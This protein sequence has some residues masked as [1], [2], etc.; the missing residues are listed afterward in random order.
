MLSVQEALTAVFAQVPTLE[1]EQAPLLETR[2]RV[3]AY[4]ALADIDNPP[5]DNSAVDGFG[6]R[7]DD[8]RGAS[9]SVP[10]QLTCVGEVPA[11]SAPV[12]GLGPGECMRVMTGAPIPPGAD[13]MVMVEDTEI[14]GNRVQISLEAGEGDHIRRAA[15]D[16]RKGQ[17]VLPRGT[18]IGPAEIALLA[19]IGQPNVSVIRTPRVAVISTG[20]EIVDIHEKPGPGKIRN[21]NS[22][23]LA[24]LVAEAGGELHSMRHIPDDRAA[25]EAAFRECSGLDGSPRADAI[26]SSGGV[27][28]GDRDFVRPVIETLGTLELWR[29]KMKPGKPL[30]FGKVGRSLFFGLPGNP[31][32]TMVTFELF[33]RPSIWKMA[34]RTTLARPSV[35]AILESPVQ[36]TSGRQEY[37][38][39]VL[40][41]RDGQYYASPTGAQGSSFLTS[42]LG[43]NGLLVIDESSGD[44]QA[45]E[46]VLAMML[47]P[48][49]CTS[50][51][52]GS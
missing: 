32:S 18:L 28:V 17:R 29:V 12:R 6:V 42:M 52:A 5:F 10:I 38:R 23:A 43:A 3:L 16:I 34:G 51:S 27:S 20:D 39:A 19:T 14:T 47:M 1:I 44:L 26:V 45:G 2:N 9:K 8:T 49:G 24:A 40:T 33:V 22:Y 25:T 50:G 13:A 4:D 15:S 48:P 7:T 41:L 37:V 11:G 35:L 36:H 30:A 31:V 46:K 21:S